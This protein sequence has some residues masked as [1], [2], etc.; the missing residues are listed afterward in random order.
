MVLGDVEGLYENKLATTER[1]S[2][3]SSADEALGDRGLRE[4]EATFGDGQKAPVAEERFR[5][6]GHLHA[7]RHLRRWNPIFNAK[8]GSVVGPEQV[9][10]EFHIV[11]VHEIVRTTDLKPRDSGKTPNG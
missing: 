5:G 1:P 8:N 10:N 11:W 7:R 9:E 6:F 3:G 2:P 4:K